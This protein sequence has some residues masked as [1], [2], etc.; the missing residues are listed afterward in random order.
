HGI[1]FAEEYGP[2]AFIMRARAEGLRDFGAAMSPTN[3][4]HIIQGIETLPLRMERHVANTGA[5][6]EF[7]RSAPQVAWVCHPDLPDHPDHELARRLMPKG[8]GSMVAFG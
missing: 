4:F 3:A 5:I 2:L 1:D 7:L 6:L 8:A